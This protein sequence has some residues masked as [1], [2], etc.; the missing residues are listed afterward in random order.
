MCLSCFLNSMWYFLLLIV[1]ALFIVYTSIDRTIAY[2]VKPSSIDPTF[3]Q[4]TIDIIEQS[5]LKNKFKLKPV[6]GNAD[7]TIQLTKR[8]DMDKWHDKKEY[9][10]DGKEIKF[11]MTWQGPKSKPR[12]YIDD[13]NWLNGVEASKLTLPQYRQYVI[14]HEFMHALGYDHQ[15]CNEKTAVNGVCPIMTQSTRGCGSYKCGYTIKPA[16]YTTKIKS[17]YRGIN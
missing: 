5:E 8:E 13:Q 16:D 15:E 6:I 3:V 1:V 4:Q 7:I 14:L 9:Y 2:Y 11:S 12:I 17:H 10:P